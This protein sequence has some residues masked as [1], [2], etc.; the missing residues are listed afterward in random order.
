[1]GR[2][3]VQNYQDVVPADGRPT[4]RPMVIVF[5]DLDRKV[6]GQGRMIIFRHHCP[7]AQSPRLIR[8]EVSIVIPYSLAIQALAAAPL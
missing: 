2:I 3:V 8:D 1:M 6:Q 5:L 4:I 7:R